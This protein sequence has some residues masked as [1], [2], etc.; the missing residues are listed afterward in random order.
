MISRVVEA[1][2]QPNRQLSLY[3]PADMLAEI[4]A[5]ARRLRRSASWVLR[6]AWKLA[7]ADIGALRPGGARDATR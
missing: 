5:E 7:R 2:R 1:K 6:R 3:F 4:R